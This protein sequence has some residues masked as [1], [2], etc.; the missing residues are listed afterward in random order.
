MRVLVAG[1]TGVVGRQLVPLLA[2]T[3]HEVVGTSRG[4]RGLATIAELGGTPLRLDVLDRDAVHDA[5]AEAKP[6]NARR[7]R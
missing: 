7:K 4:E 3:G 6:R 2:G 5:V 1:A